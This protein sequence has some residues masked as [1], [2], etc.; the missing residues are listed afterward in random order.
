MLGDVGDDQRLIEQLTP[1]SIELFN[2]GAT[3]RARMRY[4]CVVTRGPRPRKR[5]L[6]R[7]GRDLYAWLSRALYFTMHRLTVQS[8]KEP[9]S[10]LEPRQV[11]GLVH[12]F[13]HVPSPADNDGI[14]PTLSQVHGEIVAA[15]DADHLD[16]MGYF[17]D[18]DG[19]GVDWLASG[20]SFDRRAFE[21]LWQRVGEFVAGC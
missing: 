14:V 1:V 4:G 12:G 21:R 7:P 6:V 17:R 16:V 5:D 13:G 19:P 20:S 11:Q 3:D 15:T 2:A 18:D 10:P 8:G 9:S